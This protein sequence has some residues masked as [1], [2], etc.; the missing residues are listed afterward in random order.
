MG[1]VGAVIITRWS[2]GLLKQTSPILLDGSIEEEY[3]SAITEAIEKDSDN[4]V[5]DIH[6]WKVGANHYA[7]IISIVT[8]HPKSTQHYKDLLIGFDKL[9][10]TTIEVN[11]CEGE[12]CVASTS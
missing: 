7:A 1:I 8:H 9:S 4:R 5:C 11:T 12:P 3:Q 6:I 2:Y 10:H